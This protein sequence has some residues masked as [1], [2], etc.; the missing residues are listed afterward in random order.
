MVSGASRHQAVIEATVRRFRPIVVTA[1]AAILAL[2][3]LTTDPFW[4]AMAYGMIGGLVVATLLTVLFLPA[5]YCL[6][7][8]VRA[9][10]VQP[11]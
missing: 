1:G 4:G 6:C 10:S 8:G 3:P 9:E 5:L 7:F 2:A 11:A